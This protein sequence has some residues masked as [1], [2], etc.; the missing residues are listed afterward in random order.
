MKIII[1]LFLTCMIGVCETDTLSD[2]EVKKISTEIIH[3]MQDRSKCLFVVTV[4]ND[5]DKVFLT[6][7]FH[8]WDKHLDDLM[9]SGKYKKGSDAE[10]FLKKKF[11]KII[12][13]LYYSF[14]ENAI[15]IA[16]YEPDEFKIE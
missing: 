1:I 6:Y 3:K 15:K 7:Q 9:E 2:A 5:H 8:P 16:V 4:V 12:E 11:K 10:T 14:D 13:H